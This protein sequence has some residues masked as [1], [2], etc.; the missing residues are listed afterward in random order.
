MGEAWQMNKPRR[1]D[2]ANLRTGE[3][4][5]L[6]RRRQIDEIA[7]IRILANKNTSNRAEDRVLSME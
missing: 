1:S 4:L 5:I 7:R 2:D 6:G 3:N